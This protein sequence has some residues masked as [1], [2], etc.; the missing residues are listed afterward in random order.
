MPSKLRDATKSTQNYLVARNA[1]KS[2]LSG[3]G[4]SCFPL[5]SNPPG[6]KST[7][8]WGYCFGRHVDLP[9]GETPC[10]CFHAEK[11]LGGGIRL[12]EGKPRLLQ[13]AHVFYSCGIYLCQD[14]VICGTFSFFANKAWTTKNNRDFGPRLLSQE[15]WILTDSLFFVDF[16]N[17]MKFSD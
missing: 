7:I 8:P 9:R 13:Y 5:Q 12:G 4:E 15:E 11:V 14:E 2:T 16:V 3:W 6:G 17:F 10:E 1:T